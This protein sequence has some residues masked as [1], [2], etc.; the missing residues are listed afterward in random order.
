MAPRRG[1]DAKCELATRWRSNFH[2]AGSNSAF[3]PFHRM[4]PR[5]RVRG[6]CGNSLKIEE[7]QL[8]KSFTWLELDLMKAVW[9]HHPIT[10]KEVQSAIRP[11]RRLAYTTVMTI[12]YRLYV[13]GFLRRA[14][15]NRTHYYEPAV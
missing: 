1:P 13:K 12:L 15:L 8:N 14:L 9:Q 6:I 2:A 5:K 7:P 11:S 4:L 10:V 3:A